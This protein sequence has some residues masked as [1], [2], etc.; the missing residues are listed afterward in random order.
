ML[1]G[2]LVGLVAIGMFVATS[3]AAQP[4]RQSASVRLYVLDLGDLG[5]RP[6]SRNPA[7]V[8]YLIVHPRGSLLWEAGALPDAILES[9]G[10]RDHLRPGIRTT[11]AT[12]GKTL[13]AR[14]AEIGYT[15]DRISYFALSHYHDDHT[16]NANDYRFST[17]LVQKPERDAMFAE[18][19]PP[20]SDVRTY[21]ALKDAKTIILNGDHDVFGDGTVVI[22]SAPGHTPGHQLLFVKLPKTGPVLLGGD[23]YHSE[24]ERQRS[25]ESGA[26]L[27]TIPEIDKKEQ[28]R[29][30]RLAMEAFAKQN[31][32]AFWIEHELNLL[33]TL[34]KSPEYL[35]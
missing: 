26:S 23:M 8:A 24:E 5:P 10:S 15:P 12:G 33:A 14:L 27:E 35:E 30:S 20:V 2:C 17:W 7:I 6:K 1:V 34:K 18:Q 4:V 29:A 22:K 9:G 32:A 31:G 19:P 16:G 28:A 21:N 13:K 25:I 3:L 11:T